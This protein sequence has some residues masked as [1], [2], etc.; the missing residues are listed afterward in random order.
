MT[1]CEA[2]FL[3]DCFTMLC[4]FQEYG[5]EDLCVE[6]NVVSVNNV[7]WR[8]CS[9]NSVIPCGFVSE[10]TSFS[11][12]PKTPPMKEAADKVKSLLSV[13]QHSASFCIEKLTDVWLSVY[14]L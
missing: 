13:S 11:V 9:F 3:K 8:K 2:L 1:Y 4:K 10:I 12:A 5:Y 7:Q 14:V 6:G